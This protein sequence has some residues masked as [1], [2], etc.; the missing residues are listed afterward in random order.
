MEPT[1]SETI[2]ARVTPDLKHSAEAIFSKLG[3]TATDAVTLF[4]KQVVL[5][6]GLPFDVRIPNAKTAK[7]IR[8]A[9]SGKGIVKYATLDD[10]KKSLGL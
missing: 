9:Q 5:H 3:L 6:R 4:Y 7:A 8:D 2:R 1:K 10:F